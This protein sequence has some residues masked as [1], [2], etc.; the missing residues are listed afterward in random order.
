MAN[1]VVEVQTPCAIALT[2]MSEGDKR[3]LSRLREKY[4]VDVL[5]QA[6]YEDYITSGLY[7]KN[8]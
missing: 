4:G 7:S 2:Q 1:A 6:L 8:I 3:E 5:A